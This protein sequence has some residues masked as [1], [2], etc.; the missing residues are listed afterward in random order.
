[1]KRA[2]KG[3]YGIGWFFLQQAIGGQFPSSPL[4]FSAP[5]RPGR[6]SAQEAALGLELKGARTQLS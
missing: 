2:L 6:P 5:A 3:H 4:V 1:M